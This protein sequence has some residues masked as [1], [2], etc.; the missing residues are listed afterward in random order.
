MKPKVHFVVEPNGDARL[1]D[2]VEK[3]L[4]AIDVSISER[5]PEYPSSYSLIILWNLHHLIRDLPATR[6]VV[7]FHSSDLP[8]GRGWAPLYHALANSQSKHVITAILADTEVDAG[9]IIA[10]A[11]FEMQPFFVSDTLREIDEEI[12]ILMAAAIVKRYGDQEIKGIQQ[13]GETSCYPRRR[14][15]DNEVDIHRPFV[16]LIPHMRGCG[17]AHPAFFYWQGCKYLIEL[18]P[19]DTP[20]SPPDLKIEFAIPN[21]SA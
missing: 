5:L 10:K 4:V 9:E 8:L 6:N 1:H 7:V 14:P 16:E 15:E 20:N 17:S 12:C 3:H 13:N 18:K 2:L 19:E 21:D 11:R